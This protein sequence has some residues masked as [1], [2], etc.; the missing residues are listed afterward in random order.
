MILVTNLTQKYSSPRDVNCP[1]LPLIIN[2][3]KI[4]TVERAE[5]V[6]TMAVTMSK[7]MIIS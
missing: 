1:Y 6:V 5:L 2:P 3:D 4:K 7:K